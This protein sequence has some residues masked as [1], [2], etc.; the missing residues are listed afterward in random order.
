MATRWFSIATT[1]HYDCRAIRVV[2]ST[3]RPA[4]LTAIVKYVLRPQCKYQLRAHPVTPRLLQN[5]PLFDS[6]AAYGGAVDLPVGRSSPGPASGLA[7]LR[8]A[9][10]GRARSRPLAVAAHLIKSLDDSR[11]GVGV[12][13]LSFGRVM[14]RSR[15]DFH[16]VGRDG[17]LALLAGQSGAQITPAD[18]MLRDPRWAQRPGQVLVTPLHEG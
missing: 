7:T 14:A 6:S 11:C 4:G 13:V 9:L 3:E 12:G 15:H 17:E 18:R 16:L 1:R 2:S 10:A 5:T 8:A